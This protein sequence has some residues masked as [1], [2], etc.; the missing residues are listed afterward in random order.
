MFIFEDQDEYICWKDRGDIVLHIE[1]RDIAEMLVVAPLSANTLAKFSNGI[2]DNLLTNIFRA[3]A[4]KKI[5]GIWMIQKPIL[6]A[7]AMNT[8]MY[9]H[10]IT[11]K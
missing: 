11:E 8:N 3:W 10:P 6:V 9:E 2:C 4:Y 7:P 1:L 5:N